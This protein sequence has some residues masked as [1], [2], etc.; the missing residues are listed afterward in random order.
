MK[1]RLPKACS[2]RR[3]TCHVTDDIRT[4]TETTLDV[5]KDGMLEI[6]LVP[7]GFALVEVAASG[8]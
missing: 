5:D 7:N 6:L 4:Y 2:G 8:K 3:A 1:I